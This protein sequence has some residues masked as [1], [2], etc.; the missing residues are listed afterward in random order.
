MT[1]GSNMKPITK[2]ADPKSIKAK[3]IPINSA[4]NPAGETCGGCGGS[5]G[6]EDEE[7]PTLKVVGNGI[8]RGGEPRMLVIIENRW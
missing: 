1:K 6:A 7:A 5:K 3:E 2:I 8:G 4:A